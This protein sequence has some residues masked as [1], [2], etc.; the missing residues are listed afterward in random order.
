MKKFL[1][2]MPVMVTFLALAVVL[3]GV[4]IFMLARPV[5]YG[6][7]YKYESTKEESMLMVSQFGTEDQFK[8]FSVTNYIKFKNGKILTQ[9]NHYD[10]KLD[11][12]VTGEEKTAIEKAI[13]E[14]NEAKPEECYYLRS[15]NKV[16]VVLGGKT[17]YETQKK[18]VD[19]MNKKEKETYFNEGY[20][21]TV[22]AF[23]I[24]THVPE[25]EKAAVSTCAGEIVW[26]VVLGVVEVA[27][28]AFSA[29]S[30]VFFVSS[31]KKHA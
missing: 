14:A 6:M 24:K 20:M 22:N 2:K 30:V 19:N 9:K 5:S 15:G 31:K 27:L 11:S 26:A 29:L 1:S 13:K 7:N 10:Y 4:Y 17:A 16:I 28:I 18:L 21:F 12:K 8:E 25:N 3:L 23:N